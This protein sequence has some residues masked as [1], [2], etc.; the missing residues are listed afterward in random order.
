MGVGPGGLGPAKPAQV[1]LA[2][3]PRAAL[4]HRIE[5]FLNLFKFVSMMNNIIIVIIFQ[6]MGPAFLLIC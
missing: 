1:H 2:R 4:S 5:I 3:P 6:P